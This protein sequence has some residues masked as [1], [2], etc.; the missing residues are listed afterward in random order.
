MKQDVEHW[1]LTHCVCSLWF[2]KDTPLIK[3]TRTHR[4]Q[5]A[6]ASMRIDEEASQ[7]PNK[8]DG[9]TTWGAFKSPTTMQQKHAAQ[10]VKPGPCAMLYDQSKFKRLKT[11]LFSAIKGSLWTSSMD[12]WRRKAENKNKKK[13]QRKLTLQWARSGHLYQ[14]ELQK[15]GLHQLCITPIYDCSR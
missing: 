3:W 9:R 6:K 5:R 10:A 1:I 2:P 8:G 4:K 14:R 15:F 7:S 12:K 13:V 11:P